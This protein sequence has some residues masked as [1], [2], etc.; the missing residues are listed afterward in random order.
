MS[1]G[2]PTPEKKSLIAR[3]LT[4]PPVV[5]DGLTFVLIAFFGAIAIGIGND[6]AAKYIG[7]ST[8]YFSRLFC[9]AVSASLLAL[10]MFRSQSYAYSVQEKDAVKAEEKK[11]AETAPPFIRS[12][13]EH[14]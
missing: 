12:D 6:E 7:P 2:F 1:E 3:A 11:K 10:K 9:A 13:I 4:M 8:L 5:I 14:P